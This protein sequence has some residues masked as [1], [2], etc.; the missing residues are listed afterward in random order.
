[1]D[2]NQIIENFSDLTEKMVVSYNKGVIL[3]FITDQSFKLIDESVE[4]LRSRFCTILSVFEEIQKESSSSAA[5]TTRIDTML[6]EILENRKKLQTEI[7]ERVTEIDEAATNAKTTASS[8]EVLKERTNEVK[9]ML[10]GIQE[11]SVKTGILAI[12]ASIEAARAGKA[13]ESFRI[14]A[15]EVRS[16]STQTGTFAKSIEAKLAELQHTVNDINNS[17]SLFLTLFLKFQKSFTGV[18]SNFDENSRTL[19]EAGTSLAEIT[20][21]IKEQDTTIREGFTS[22]KKIDDFLQETSTILS[23]AQTTHAHLGTLLQKNKL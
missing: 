6:E 20:S 11:V 1:M 14:I 17:M 5:N 9:D 23:A 2:T 22:L 21:S 8:F 18:L 7:H 15:N 16:L 12:N 13:G 19:N 10:A 4:Q 3:D